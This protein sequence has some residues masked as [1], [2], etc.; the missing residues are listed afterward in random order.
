MES[1]VGVGQSIGDRDYMED[2]CS[3]L[4]LE[5]S[6]LAGV[7]DGHGG[8]QIARFCSENFLPHVAGKLEEM[9]EDDHCY[10]EA[11]HDA[12]L[13]MDDKCLKECDYTKLDDKG[14]EIVSGSTAVVALVQPREKILTVASVGD[15]RAILSWNKMAVD[16][17]IAHE[18][19]IP[20]EQSRIE[21]AGGKIQPNG[22]VTGK[23]ERGMLAMS[24]S[25]GDFDFKLDPE[26]ALDEQIV[27]A[28]PE[29]VEEELKGDEDF[30]VLSS[31]GIWM[32]SQQVVDL[33]GGMMG[34][35][36]PLGEICQK[37]IEKADSDDNMTVIIVD[38]AKLKQ[39]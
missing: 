2:Y 21:A 26:L 24:R 30:L 15:S 34:R 3:Y 6:L 10:R 28:V 5:H 35:K 37:L 36:V 14:D 1:L 22:S 23:D 8:D 17:A 39:R 29:I 12:F 19:E 11:L 38:L 16:L 31:D 32:D 4:D 9:G 25:I 20:E 33:V 7:F 13:E 18:P 27:I